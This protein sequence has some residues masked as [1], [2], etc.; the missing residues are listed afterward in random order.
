MSLKSNPS[1]G[2]QAALSK[3]SETSSRALMRCNLTGG[4]PRAGDGRSR[5][6]SFGSGGGGSFGLDAAGGTGMGSGGSLGGDLVA[7]LITPPIT[8]HTHDEEDDAAPPPPLPP[9]PPPPEP[10]PVPP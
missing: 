3:I 9:E 8:W 2:C 1:T 4:P 10:P 5:Q 6:G 7:E